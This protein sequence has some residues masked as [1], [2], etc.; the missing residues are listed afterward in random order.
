MLNKDQYNQDE[1]NDYYAQETKG[2]EISATREE[3]NGAKIGIIIALLLALGGGGFFAWKSMN[4][5]QG[6]NSTLASTQ[7]SAINEPATTPEST[8]QAKET[9]TPEATSSEE[10][11]AK[12][13]VQSIA[14][15]QES[16]GIG[17]MSPEDMAKIVQMVTQQMRAQQAQQQESISQS[18][19]EDPNSL[20]AS[21]QNAEVDSLTSATI[22][23]E[24]IS[25]NDNQKQATTTEKPNTYNKVVVSSSSSAI[26]DLSKLSDEISNVINEEES[27]TTTNSDYTKSLK[28]EVETRAKEMR[29]VTVKKGDTLGKI[30]QRIYGNVMDYKKIYEANPDILRRADKIYIGQRLR[31]PE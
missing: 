8:P 13:V 28:N 15:S 18:E 31:V 2:A 17:Q 19:P 9:D 1:Y 22:T 14:S 5:D 12:A 11:T 10:E 26:D 30:A 27:T 29:Y 3:S 6:D 24:K 7:N 20:E 4:K 23:P 16:K 25:S 21:L